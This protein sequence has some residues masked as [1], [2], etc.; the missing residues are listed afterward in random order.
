MYCESNNPQRQPYPEQPKRSVTQNVLCW[1][2]DK[3]LC[4]LLVL[5]AFTLGLIL[6]TVFAR[7]LFFALP[8]LI[9]LGVLLVILIVK[10]LIVKRCKCCKK[11]S[12]ND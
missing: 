9:V 3:I 1:C 6:G 7:I 11:N 2:A 4:F 10:T 5:F 8:A 12:C